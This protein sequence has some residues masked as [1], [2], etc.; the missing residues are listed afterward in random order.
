MNIF[1]SI[2]KL[3]KNS[4]N[5][6]ERFEPKRPFNRLSDEEEKK[7]N[8]NNFEES[9]NNSKLFKSLSY[10][11]NF[12]EFKDFYDTPNVESGYK[13]ISVPI[14]FN[15]RNKFVFIK[16][17]I[18]WIAITITTWILIFGISTLIFYLLF[19]F[20]NFNF[21]EI[22]AIY[23]CLG[24]ALSL[25]YVFISHVFIDKKRKKDS[26]FKTIKRKRIYQ[27]TYINIYLWIWSKFFYKF[28]KIIDE[29]E[30]KNIYEWNDFFDNYLQKAYLLFNWLM[31]YYGNFINENKIEN[32]INKKIR[33]YGKNKY[34]IRF[35]IYFIS[36]M[37]V[38]V[39]PITVLFIFLIISY[40][41]YFIFIY[42]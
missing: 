28:K 15:K 13:A 12:K 17:L 14:L 25:L 41:P 37:S 24:I 2:L 23:Y 21:S 5:I 4:S 18:C 16:S 38:V 33:K 11:I 20:S 40:L 32:N 39:Y 1:N 26:V 34:P 27:F 42:S 19:T 36:V 22:S 3:S 6:L 30:N 29:K 7:E 35:K 9:N 31:T 8:W 10:E